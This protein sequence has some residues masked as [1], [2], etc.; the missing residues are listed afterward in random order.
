MAR[1]AL[2]WTLEDV[3]LRAGVNRMTVSR[4]EIEQGTP[5]P[6]TLAAIRQAFEQAGI[7]FIPS[8][9][10]LREAADA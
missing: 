3:A 2:R 7:E 4:F 1:A 6:V 8:G 9:V 5:I 10:R